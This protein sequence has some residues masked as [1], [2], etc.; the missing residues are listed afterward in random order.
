MMQRQ[1]DGR[2]LRGGAAQMNI[3]GEAKFDALITGG[4][5]GQLRGD[6][7]RSMRMTVSGINALSPVAQFS[8]RNVVMFA[9]PTAGEAALPPEEDVVACVIKRNAGRKR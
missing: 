5:D 6:K 9:E 2:K 3:A 7:A 8:E 1:Q 4:R